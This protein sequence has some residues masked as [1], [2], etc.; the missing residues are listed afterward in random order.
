MKM[1]AS[2]LIEKLQEAI[3]EH[4]DLPV[5]KEGSCG[6]QNFGYEVEDVEFRHAYDGDP[7]RITL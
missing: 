4:G 7:D 1:K 6:F 5:H 3:R 2:E